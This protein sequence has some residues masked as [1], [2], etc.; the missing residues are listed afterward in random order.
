MSSPQQKRGIF[1]V[2]GASAT[3]TRVS[4]NPCGHGRSVQTPLTPR[5]PSMLLGSTAPKMQREGPALVL[6]R[7]TTNPMTLHCKT[8]IPEVCSL[9]AFS[10]CTWAGWAAIG[11]N[12][13]AM[14]PS[15][16]W[17]TEVLSWAGA[18]GSQVQLVWKS[19][20]SFLGPSDYGHI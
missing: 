7:R 16:S 18:D 3:W 11:S 19:W 2:P 12:C 1:Q 17:A 13:G 14:G 20:A 10:C 5:V 6:L 15:C 9:L 8:F 4:R